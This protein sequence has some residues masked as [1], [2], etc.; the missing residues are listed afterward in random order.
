M[1]LEAGLGFLLSLVAFLRAELGGR[2]AKEDILRALADAKTIQ[3]YLEWLRRRDQQD[4]IREIESS[5]G[6]LL[7]EVGTIG[8]Q[9]D[10]FANAVRTKSGD[11]EQ[12]IRELNE[13]VAPPILSPVSLPNRPRLST[14]LR[15]RDR[16][17]QWLIDNERDTL[18]VGQPGA[19]KTEL[20]Y[21]LAQASDAKFLLSDNAD[22]AVAALLAGPPATVLVDDA[23]LR[24]SLILRLRHLRIEQGLGFKIIAVCWPFEKDELQ[25]T[26]QVAEESVLNL[27][28]LPRPVIAEIIRDVT[29]AKNVRVSDQ[30]IRVVAKQARGKP[31]LAASLSLATIASTGEALLSGELLLQDLSPFLRRVAGAEGVH[32]LA[33]FACGGKIGLALASV[34]KHLG[35]SVVE[36]SVDAQRIALAGVLE[37]TSKETLCVQPSFLRSALIKLAFF[38]TTGVSL[39]WDVCKALIESSND[40]VLGYLELV[41]AR[42]LAGAAIDDELLHGVAA[43]FDDIRFWKAL[44]ELDQR[45]CAWVLETKGAISADI[46][47][48]ALR[49]HPET[50]IPTML[51]AAAL[52]KRPLNIIP[53]ADM[54][55]LQDW[56]AASSGA[57][58]VKRRRTLLD[59]AIAFLEKNENVLTALEAIRSVFSLN[60]H[61]TD[62]DPADPRTIRF[63]DSVLALQGAKEVFEMWKPFLQAAKALP[64]FPWPGIPPLIEN[65]IHTDTRR[66]SV[67]PADYQEFLKSSSHE[68]VRQL[69]PFA[70]GGEAALR[71]LRGMT[72]KLGIHTEEIPVSPEFMTFYPE[73]RLDIDWREREEKQNLEAIDLA[74]RWQKRPFAE[75]VQTIR[76]Y[77]RQAEDF[78]RVWPRTTYIFCERLAELIRPT[79]EELLLAIENL[80]PMAVRPFLAAALSGNRL[81]GAHL[82][83][84]LKRPDLTGVLIEF[85]L[86]GNT[87]NLYEALEERL[88]TWIGLVEGMCL[89]NEVSVEMLQRLLQHDDQHVRF[90]TALYM[91]RSKSKDGIPKI[92]FDLWRS[93]IVQ[94][95]AESAA[96]DKEE[97]P[98]D[99]RELLASHPTI[100]SDAL[101]KLISSGSEFHGFVAGGMIHLLVGRLEKEEKRKLLHRCKHLVYSPLPRL[102]VGSDRDLYRE[103]LSI[104]ELKDF[105]LAALSGDPNEANWAELAKLALVAG[106][107]HRDIAH[108]VESSSYSW[109]GGLSTYYQEWV[110][111]FERL[112]QHHDADMQKIA[113]EGLKSFIALRNRERK[114]ERQEEI[115]GWD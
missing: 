27:E 25:Q 14:A 101:D 61:E 114:M 54:R 8:G 23:G 57:D 56:I 90:E 108:A 86:K 11:L 55:I 91:F 38:P 18:L 83:A 107:S 41:S 29:T 51:K 68:M 33:A 42:G 96:T 84:C 75:V 59:A 26:L 47:R 71:W 20:L 95:L 58:A 44:A 92:I 15:G 31:G 32:L 10:E 104:A 109:T 13:R 52:E 69:I 106:F 34:A 66:G 2:W 9:L 4:L 37:Q 79:D 7:R 1:S 53:N 82:E 6:D 76:D 102:L 98:Y 28:G 110:E 115:H 45:N 5:K 65:W 16:E 22:L 78:G 36:I 35:K 113:D 46:K 60:H 89:R 49:Y 85:T 94:G 80:P 64:T 24:G 112:R 111:R 77:E 74:N 19:G 67:L 105:H 17:L 40:P 50:I 62:S 100:G 70:A 99:L 93:N 97:V 103:L 48:A 12:R 43:Q 63:R 72:K 73:E 30:F 21:S 3:A 87:P 39:P 88:P 81:S